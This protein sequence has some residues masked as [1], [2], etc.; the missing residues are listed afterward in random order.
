MKLVGDPT[1]TAVVEIYDGFTWGRICEGLWNIQSAAIVC[2]HFGYST[3]LG[4]VHVPMEEKTIRPR[5]LQ[6]HCKAEHSSLQQCDT[7]IHPECL[8]SKFEAGV[9]CSKGKESAGKYANQLEMHS[10]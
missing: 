9:I 4:A 8:C 2:R 10:P 7:Q 5:R 1:E 3:A 6:I